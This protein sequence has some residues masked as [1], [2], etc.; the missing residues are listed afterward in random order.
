[1]VI[2]LVFVTSLKS[3]LTMLTIIEESGD[4]AE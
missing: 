2:V 3:E 1:M 4:R